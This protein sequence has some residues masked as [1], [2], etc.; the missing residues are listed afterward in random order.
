MYFTLD[1]FDVLYLG[2][3]E[4]KKKSIHLFYHQGLS[5]ITDM[6]Q[7][8]TTMEY[9]QIACPDIMLNQ[10]HDPED[11]VTDPLPSFVDSPDS[12]VVI[13]HFWNIVLH[14]PSLQHIYIKLTKPLVDIYEQQQQ[15]RPLL[16]VVFI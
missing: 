11:T 1:H 9:L 5:L 4:K 3:L 13:E 15:Q 8:H 14:H 16:E 2:D 7:R 6:L 12:T 10:P